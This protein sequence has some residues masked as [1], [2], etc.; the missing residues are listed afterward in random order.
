M[1]SGSGAETLCLLLTSAAVAAGLIGS[2]STRWLLRAEEGRNS[3]KWSAMVVGGPFVADLLFFL[4]FLAGAARAKRDVRNAAD[5]SRCGA[6]LEDAEVEEE[7]W[8]PLMSST[9]P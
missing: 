2:A 8:C 6:L 3:P 7:D 5:C 1:T 9:M 4:L